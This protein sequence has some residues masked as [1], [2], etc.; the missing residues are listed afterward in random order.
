MNIPNIDNKGLQQLYGTESESTRG[1]D[2]TGRG[3]ASQAAKSKSLTGK[4]EASVS[5]NARLLARA[6]AELN[7][8]PDVRAEL[9]ARYRQ[10]VESGSY[11]VQYDHLARRLA[12]ILKAAE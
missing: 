4:D 3:S 7:N 1:V 2:R 5:E 8:T 10:E 11:Q 12:P 9:V 6:A